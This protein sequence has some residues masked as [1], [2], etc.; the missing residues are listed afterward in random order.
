M[1][2]FLKYFGFLLIMATLVSCS[3]S[4]KLNKYNTAKQYVDEFPGRMMQQQVFHVN[5]S[6][7]ELSIRVLPSLIPTLKSNQLYISS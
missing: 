6:L 5:D 1:N 3:Q 2:R 4:N 7:S